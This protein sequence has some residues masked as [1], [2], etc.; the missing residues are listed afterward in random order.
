MHGRESSSDRISRPVAAA[1]AAG[2]PL[3]ALR[4][5]EPTARRQSLREQLGQ[6]RDALDRGDPAEALAAVDRALALDPDYLAAQALRE[7][8]L[9]PAPPVARQASPSIAVDAF[10][11]ESRQP[12][13]V[14]LTA[15]ASAAGVLRVETRV[16]ARRIEKRAEAARAALA[17]GR[18]HDARAAIDE[19]AAIDPEHP[20]HPLLLA[21]LQAHTSMARR[22]THAGP[23]L[24]AAA[25]CAAFTMAGWYWLGP[26]DGAP[27]TAVVQPAAPAAAAERPG[28]P[29]PPFVA[30]TPATVTAEAQTI[31][32][33]P[34][35]APDRPAP[36]A[37]AEPGATSTAGNL[38]PAP[39]SRASGIGPITLPPPPPPEPAPAQVQG[40]QPFV[41][42]IAP[43]EPSGPS[44]LPGALTAAPQDA[45]LRPVEGASDAAAVARPVEPTSLPTTPAVRDEELV[46]RAL[47]QY[48]QAYDTLDA[49]AAQAVWPGVDSAALQR[50]VD[51]LASQ[52][53]T[54]QSCQLQVDGSSASAECRGSA[55][56]TPRV[57][58]REARDE[59]RNW[60][61]ALRK[62]TNNAWQIES[63]R[64]A[65]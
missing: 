34:P 14:A 26:R 20:E 38:I 13:P 49:R 21:E 11:R 48:R 3:A 51:G 33:S 18:T 1:V 59:P 60:S 32:P 53:L 58:S 64:V 55:Q 46:L 31:E 56:Y 19:I 25:V 16:R 17:C 40:A 50:A 44:Q 9:Q 30:P 2:I 5:V 52:R 6:A 27:P 28:A 36:A 47:Q 8:I 29:A 43:I 22:R 54:F 35:V 57:G 45:R 42:A 65:R 23:A 39:A 41:P 7:R 24:A 37:A 10:R 15:S 61:F 62:T 63:A 12:A 4:A